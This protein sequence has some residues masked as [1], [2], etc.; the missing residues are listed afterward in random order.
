MENQMKKD[1]IHDMAQYGNRVL[2]HEERV[3][4]N[5][6]LVVPKWETIKPEDIETPLEVYTSILLEGYHVDYL[7]IPMYSKVT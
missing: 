5:T 4:G 2:L 6:F 1:L 3:E 7:R